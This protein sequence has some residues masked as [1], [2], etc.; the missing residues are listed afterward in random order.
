MV[1]VETGLYRERY[2]S[3][4]IAEKLGQITGTRNCIIFS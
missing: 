3:R 2:T 1:G 4:S